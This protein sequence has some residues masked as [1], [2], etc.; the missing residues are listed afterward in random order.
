MSLPGKYV[1]QASESARQV[2]LPGKWV[3]QAR[4]SARQ[5]SLPGKWVCQTS[6][7]A[8][9]VSMPGKWDCQASESGRK[10]SMPGKWV[11]QWHARLRVLLSKTN[12]N[13]ISRRGHLYRRTWPKKYSMFSVHRSFVLLSLTKGLASPLSLSVPRQ[14][15]LIYRTRKQQYS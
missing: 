1:C 9:Q 13:S 15:F 6:E 7:S 3:C 8:R 10:V 4:E 14:A 11:C 5:V 2:S 12:R